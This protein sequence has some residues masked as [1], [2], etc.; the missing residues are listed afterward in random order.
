MGVGLGA[1]APCL[2]VEASTSSTC[3]LINSGYA[4]YEE[5]YVKLIDVKCTVSMAKMFFLLKRL[6][7][8]PS[9]FE[10]FRWL[11]SN[12]E[13]LVGPLVNVRVSGIFEVRGRVSVGS[14]T[15]ESAS[16]GSLVS[17]GLETAP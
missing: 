2:M 8:L 3:D 13:G 10:G 14:M 15:I 6:R 16:Y 11:P 4:T 5:T 9:E 17:I 7:W 1:T 12:S